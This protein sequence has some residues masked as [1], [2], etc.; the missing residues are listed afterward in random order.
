LLTA[1]AMD[2]PEV[3]KKNLVMLVKYLL[4][5]LSKIISKRNIRQK[6]NKTGRQSISQQ[7]RKYEKKLHT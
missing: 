2:Y 1:G 7:R 6:Y 3:K 4:R 5:G